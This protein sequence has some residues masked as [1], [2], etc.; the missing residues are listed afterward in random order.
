MS[1]K[2]EKLVHEYLE[3]AKAAGVNPQAAQSV[4]NA[5]AHVPHQRVHAIKTPNAL[6]PNQEE[7]GSLAIGVLTRGRQ[8]CPQCA[9]VLPDGI[10]SEIVWRLMH[11]TR[12]LNTSIISLF[13]SGY[14]IPQARNNLVRAALEA[15][16]KY[17]WMTDDDMML[18]RN[19][20]IRLFQLAKQHPEAGLVGAWS[21]S[22]TGD[23]R[24]PFV[25]IDPSL[26]GGAWWGIVNLYHDLNAQIIANHEIVSKGGVAK[27]G[28]VLNREDVPPIEVAAVG[29]GV[30]ILNL[31][32]ALKLC[33]PPEKPCEKHKLKFCWECHDD[34]KGWFKEGQEQKG[35]SSRTWGQD[36][37]YCQQL[38]DA[39]ATV[40][41]DPLSFVP[42]F[43]RKNGV[44]FGPPVI[45]KSV[46]AE[47]L[48]AAVSQL[49]KR[50]GGVLA[51]LISTPTPKKKR[52]PAK[53]KPAKKKPAKKPAKKGKS[54]G[55][56]PRRRKG[57]VPRKAR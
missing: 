33:N 42:H 8:E 36:I 3:A 52:K 47:A 13:A 37:H 44:V 23:D 38:R 29:T 30:V 49:P 43:E 25:Y 16:V 56:H 54:N 7:V 26:G 45:K 39:G 11:M 51:D 12:P 24:E 5:V 2:Q 4:M 28:T 20:V 15:G 41:V 57:R 31:E 10:D 27:P 6:K 18:S 46:K 21:V 35:G 53:K 19:N 48:T 50:G 9:A 40:L 14:K 22:K 17:L 1:K 32:W 55:V 34:G